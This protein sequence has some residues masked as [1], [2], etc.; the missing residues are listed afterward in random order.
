[1]RQTALPGHRARN[2]GEVIQNGPGVRQM[3][4]NPISAP[5]PGPNRTSPT[6]RDSSRAPVP[7]TSRCADTP[8]RVPQP[9]LWAKIDMMF[10]ALSSLGTTWNCYR[11]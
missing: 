6:A 1:M 4:A 8:E 7:G 11:K 5:M 9:R 3:H 10:G 2:N